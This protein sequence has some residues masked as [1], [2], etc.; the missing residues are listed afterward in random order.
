MFGGSDL[1]EYNLPIPNHGARQR[2]SR[3]FL[4]E[5]SCNQADMAS[6]AETL[7][8]SLTDDQ[9]HVFTVFNSILEHGKDD[10]GNNIIF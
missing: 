6:Q 7:Q 9:R 3:E 1:A 10:Q 4:R 8:T 5:T 2:L